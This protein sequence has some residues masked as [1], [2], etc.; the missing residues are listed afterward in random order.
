MAS[1]TPAA[2]TPGA[3][4][5]MLGGPAGE[6]VLECTQG[7]N[8]VTSLALQAHAA[9]ATA[10]AGPAG[11]VEE[12]PGSV[13]GTQFP[14]LRGP[15]IGR[16]SLGRVFRAVDQRSGRHMAVKEVP[17]SACDE[18][19]GAFAASLRNEVDILS[20]LDHPNIV[21]YIGHDFVDHCLYMY[22]EYMPAGTLTHALNEFGPFDESLISL[23]SRQLLLG[24]DYLHSQEPAVVH[25]DIKGS[26]VLLG[27]DCVAKLADFGCSKRT[28][29]TM[30][31]TMRGSIPWM[32]P[33]VIAH[34]RYGKAADVWSFGCV[35]IEMGTAAVPWGRFENQMAALIK[36]GLSQDLPPLAPSASEL[37][38]SF[39]REHV[40]HRDPSLR[41]SAGELLSHAFVVCDAAS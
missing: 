40:L 32:A 6:C 10:A 13:E 15:L 17:V 35:V 5:T 21:K 3:R 14:W 18:E 2:Q 27:T 23:Y 9:Q 36:I 7:A 31:H 25:R 38:A 4:K 39:L 11:A 16:G 20:G 29:S 28:D 8:G 30:T 33:E 1:E 41:L 22:M 26:N 12:T 24:L 34:S 19:D 37:C